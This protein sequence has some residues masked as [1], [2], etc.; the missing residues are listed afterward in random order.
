L[1]ELLLAEMVVLAL[2]ILVVVVVVQAEHFLLEKL[3]LPLEQI[4]L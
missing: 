1:F 4:M 2:D 3:Q